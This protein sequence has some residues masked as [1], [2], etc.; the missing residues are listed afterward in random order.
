MLQAPLTPSELAELA[1]LHSKIP[2]SQNAN[3]WT[4]NLRDLPD[5][6]VELLCI[7]HGGGLTI[8]EREITYFEDILLRE[9][10]LGY[11]FPVY[12]PGALP[13]GLNGGGVFYL[14]DMRAPA[15]DSE[16]PILVAHSSYLDFNGATLVAKDVHELLS[17][18]KNV[19]EFL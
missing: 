14:F 10:L 19:E 17:D 3:G 9:Y 2:G 4:I 7:S 16:F 11:E 5:S 12:M 18:K 6:Y 1:K 13:F 15:R 8:G